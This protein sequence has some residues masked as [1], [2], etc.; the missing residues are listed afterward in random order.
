MADFR[1]S[2]IIHKPVNE[3]F[4]YM[5]GMENVQEIMPIVAEMEKLTDGEIGKGTKFKETRMVRGNKVYADVEYVEFNQDQSFTSRSNSNGLIVEYK[6]VFHEIEEGTQVE[7]EAFVKTSGLRMK[8]T[9]PMIVKMIKREDG[10]QLEN[11]RD[12]LEKE[13]SEISD[14]PIE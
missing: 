12:M 5:A 6:Y 11:L 3:V 8:L 9:R 14:L 1:S 10:Y 13:E 4:R 2:V 7:L